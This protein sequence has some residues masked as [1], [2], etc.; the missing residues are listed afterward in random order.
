MLLDLLLVAAGCALLFFGGDWLV[1]S[2]CNLAKRLCVSPIIVALVVMGFGTSAPELVVAI[3]AMLADAPDIAM[4]NAL[5]S[6]LANLF[7]VLAL[8]ALV[9]PIA[10]NPD[11]LRYDGSAMLGAALALWLASY[12]GTITRLDAGL[13]ILTVFVY[14][15]LR[16]RSLADDAATDLSQEGLLHTLSILLAALVALPVG[17]HVFVAGAANIAATLGISEA[18]IGLT[19]VA[20]GTSLPEIAACLAAA[21]RKEAEIVLGGILGSNVFNSTIVIAGSAAVG[22][23]PVAAVFQTFWIPAM[24]GASL[25]TFLFLRTGFRLSRLEAMAMLALYGGVFLV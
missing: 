23:I 10:V 16:W 4:G 5:G 8:C 3:K 2:V 6:N 14:M 21:L 1:D 20:I 19:V 15:G 22:A 13:L 12:D 24:V 17:A 18:L 7:L 11:T 25:V 9:S